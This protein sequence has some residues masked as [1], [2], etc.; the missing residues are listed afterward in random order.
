[1]SSRRQADDRLGNR[2]ASS[3]ERCHGNGLGPKRL[4]VLMLLL[5][6]VL[7]LLGLVVAV[8]L[9]WLVCR[10]ARG[11][12][13]VLEM[14]G[15]LLSRAARVRRIRHWLARRVRWVSRGLGHGLRRGS[16][17][18]PRNGGGSGRRGRLPQGRSIQRS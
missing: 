15:R 5:L 9:R 10:R 18:G 13:F 14:S 12:G 11:L 8:V 7:P 2:G 17:H 4:V 3:R 1:M 6:V 16:G